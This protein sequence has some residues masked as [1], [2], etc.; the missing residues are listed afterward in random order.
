MTAKDQLLQELDQVPESVLLK[1]LEFVLS[2]KTE[3]E[4]KLESK[5]WQAYLD[6]ERER[7]EVY[8]RLANS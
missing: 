1:V 2:L 6:S 5:T 3:E 4:Q 8:R 7:K